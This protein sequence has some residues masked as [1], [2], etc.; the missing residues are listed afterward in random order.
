M[1]ANNECSAWWHLRV[2]LY[3][4]RKVMIVGVLCS[5]WV[6][7]TAALQAGSTMGG[8]EPR[9]SDD[10]C[11]VATRMGARAAANYTFNPSR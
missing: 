9:S 4:Q 3:H 6:S 7:S 10:R 5:P 2:Q 8:G 11:E 1:R